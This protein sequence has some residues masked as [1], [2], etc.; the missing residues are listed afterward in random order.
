[1]QRRAFS[2]TL[3]RANG[4]THGNGVVGMV[5]E[6][7]NKWER[8]APLC[9]E[10]VQRLTQE[11]G[12]RVLV[13]P[14]DRR[15]FTDAEYKAAGAE[16]TTD[17]SP[18]GTIFGV[19]QV[20]VEN[21]L[22]DRTYVFFSHVIKAQPE[23]M[24][25]LDTILDRNIR[26]MDYECIN[27]DGLRS[28]PRLIAFG[29]YAGR[30]GVI[31]GLRGLGERFLSL[32][33]STPFLN[34]GSSYMYPDLVSAK[35]AVKA[36]GDGISANGLGGIPADFAPLVIGFTG[37]GNVSQGAQEIFKLLPHEFVRPEDLPHL[38]KSTDRVYGV[39]A[40]EEHLVRKKDG[41]PLTDRSHYYAHPEEYEARFHED[42][43]PHLSMLVNCTYWDHRY[44]RVLT[45]EQTKNLRAKQKGANGR[46]PKLQ[47]VSDVSCDIGGSV[48]FLMKS[49]HIEAP[50][51][52]YDFG[53][54]DTIVDDDNETTD[55]TDAT[56]ATDEAANSSNIGSNNVNVHD[57]MDG[58]GVIMCGVDILPSELPRESSKHFGDLLFDMVEDLAT[59][60]GAK[61]F[62]EQNDLPL[63]LKGA[64]IA[65]HGN[66]TPNFQYI[67]AMRAERDREAA[68]THARKM[69][70]TAGSTVMRIRG[71]LFDTGLINQILDLLEEHGCSFYVVELDVRP[72]DMFGDNAPVS[73]AD[74]QIS[75]EGGRE[76]LEE[77][78]QLVETLISV[79]PKS[80]AE[81][82]ELPWDYCG[83]NFTST[84]HDEDLRK[85]EKDSAGGVY[86]AP[87]ATSGSSPAF[88]KEEEKNEN[89][90]VLGAGLVAG[91][92]V[93][94]L[95]RKP[96]RTVTV[97]SGAPG[98]AAKLKASLGDPQNVVPV[99]LDAVAQAD[100]VLAN[101]TRSDVVLS[102]LPAT[103][104][105]PIMEHAIKNGIPGV[106]ASYVNDEM[107]A[108][109]AAAKAANVPILN[110][111]GLDPGMDHMSAMKVIHEIQ[112]EGKFW[113]VVDSDWKI[114]WYYTPASFSTFL[115]ICLSAYLPICLSFCL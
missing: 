64:C 14:S 28:A 100:E 71:H 79:T 65:A 36:V 24:E 10:H 63:P 9:P 12:M 39:I 93:E 69:Y 48:E 115:P 109:D 68:Q 59:S 107:R 62:E 96:G 58:P 78:L 88:V 51:F 80:E 92:A 90:L 23:N 19:K 73:S 32:G 7:Y 52:R 74:V 56:D 44:P 95:A 45:I 42:V 112:A 46:E 30:A 110:E 40:E 11:K 47:M 4:G 18:C 61:S 17:L 113:L 114:N 84:L 85:T 97:V 101:I 86:L 13:A 70:E 89:V 49:T 22:P 103:M 53:E 3:Q 50:F 38:P 33:Y 75:T 108:L 94:Y 72:N 25:L 43:A 83:G 111:M 27:Q 41:S 20:P 37:N 16:I 29:G 104:H 54:N 105:V 55:V 21:L 2:T 8:R 26:L 81:I 1:M 99:Q 66:L 5:S 91:P 76:K 57:D 82:T 60:N 106:T 87:S 102:L 31:D 34:L 15:V 67:S 77:I 6:V 35:A 98:E